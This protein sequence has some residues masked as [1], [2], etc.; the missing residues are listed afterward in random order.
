MTSL[1]V[2]EYA[3]FEVLQIFVSE[4]IRVLKSRDLLI[5]ESPKSENIKVVSV[6]FYYDPTYIKS[7]T[8]LL[9][10]FLTGFY[11]FERLK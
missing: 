6:S 11:G 8:S 2:V 9:L 1:H 7:I 4:T 5:L 3:S 10:S